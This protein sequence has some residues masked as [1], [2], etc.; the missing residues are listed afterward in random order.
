[1]R[2]ITR[3]YDRVW[4]H[5]LEEFRNCEAPWEG[6]FNIGRDN[7]TSWR[8]RVVEDFY[9]VRCWTSIRTCVGLNTI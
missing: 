7:K 5:I 4:K 3:D 1:M 2:A 6:R 9:D 8:R